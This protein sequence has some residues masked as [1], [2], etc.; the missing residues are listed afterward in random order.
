M[1][2][3]NYF[4]YTF[5]VIISNRIYSQRIVYLKADSL[6]F[7]KYHALIL[8]TGKRYL[9][10]RN[11]TFRIPIRFIKKGKSNTYLGAFG[12]GKNP[13]I[14]LYRELNISE[15]K[16]NSLES[17]YYYQLRQSKDSNNELLNIG[18]LLV[19]NKIYGKRVKS[20]KELKD[21]F[22]FYCDKEGIYF[23]YDSDLKGISI[24][25]ASNINIIELVDNLTLEDIIL[26]GTGGHAIKGINVSNILVR[27]VQISN[28]GGSY[29]PM[30]ASG[31]VRYGNGIEF[32]DGGNDI[33]VINSSIANV[34]DAAVTVQGT[35][36]EATFYNVLFKKNLIE[37]C[38]QSFE[39]WVSGSKSKIQK[40]RFISNNCNRAGMG[41]SH[42]VRPDTNVGAHILDYYPS[43]ND[44]RV[45]VKKNIFRDFQS[46]LIYFKE[47]PRI[48]SKRLRFK[49]NLIINTY[50]RPFITTYN[51]V[52]KINFLKSIKIKTS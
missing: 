27:N 24:R 14:E 31:D 38:E 52:L 20:L 21:N 7:T 22:D 47:P 10:R 44:V 34:Y 19:E 41:W 37:S 45:T 51:R 16:K 15:L 32:W 25:V 35:R 36:N 40:C 11:D 4:L 13:V 6:K 50:N 2:N 48:V 1:K 29:L 5:L 8:E 33:K 30:F 17:I 46:E 49:N 18:H 9:L 23:Y 26:R 12:K 43:I 3:V 42:S 28:I 39:Y